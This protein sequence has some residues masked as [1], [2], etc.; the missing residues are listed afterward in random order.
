MTSFSKLARLFSGVSVTRFRPLP[1]CNR[2]SAFYLLIVREA[3]AFKTS[4]GEV[5][6]E[7]LQLVKLEGP[8]FPSCHVSISFVLPRRQ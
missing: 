2:N 1:D 8:S 7:H 4:S 6:L 5:A 3:L